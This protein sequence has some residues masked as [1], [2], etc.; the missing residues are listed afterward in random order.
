VILP[1]IDELLARI[2]WPRLAKVGPLL[3]ATDTLVTCAGFED[4][5]LAYL[6][7]SVNAGSRGFR[8]VG[9]D[10]RPEVLENRVD[11]LHQLAKLAGADL[12]VI[13]YDRQE[14]ESAAEIFKYARKGERILLDI[15]GM[16]RLLIVQLIAAA[17]RE[18]LVRRMD[19][20]YTEADTYPPTQEEVEVRLDDE[21]DYLSVLNFIS[22]GVLGITI[23]PE[24]STIAMQGQPIRLIAFP[25]FNPTQLAAVCAEIQ[26]SSFSIVNGAPPSDQNSW[27][28]DAIRRLNNIDSIREK[29]EF[30]ASTLD[31]RDTLKLL[32]DLYRDHGALEKLVISPT[33]SK[34]QSVA[35]GIACGFLRDIQVVYPTPRSFP[36]PANYTKGSRATY[37]LCLEPFSVLT[38]NLEEVAEEA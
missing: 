36:S 29:E 24:L 25:S 8:I 6:S 30:N 10:Y 9:V 16:S 23:V 31:Y 13:T 2:K 37:R 21:K 14:G 17:V 33:G 22:S 15:S 5:S 26:A 12:T 32:L 20:I 38:T 18:N 35:V 11:E 19:V 27:R 28:R 1:R 4:R 34:M 3:T 7:G